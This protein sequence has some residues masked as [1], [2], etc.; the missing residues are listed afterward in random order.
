MGE[1]FKVRE[2]MALKSI[3]VKKAEILDGLDIIVFD[4]ERYYN[5][6]LALHTAQATDLILD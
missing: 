1:K 4:L 2:I 5:R 6:V 3:P